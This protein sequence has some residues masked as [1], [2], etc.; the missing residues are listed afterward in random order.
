[1]AAA[2]LAAT[3]LGAC[4][5]D[6]LSKE[7][8]IDAADEACREADEA[9][10]KMGQPRV[11]EGV[12]DYVRE[13]RAVSEELVADLRALDPPADDE[14]QVDRMIDGLERATNLLEPLARASIDRD[15]QELEELQRE[16]EQV[17]DEV[18]EAAESYGFETCG[19]K[20]LDPVR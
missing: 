18:S 7:E 13:A 3:V 10:G 11:E 17:T 6:A 5:E 20:V 4:T 14:E 1:M 15:T 16:V 2:V 19:A 9:I 12:F 8:Y